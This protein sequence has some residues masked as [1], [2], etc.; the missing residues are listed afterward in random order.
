MGR[1]PEAP[2]NVGTKR[3]MSSPIVANAAFAFGKAPVTCDDP[4]MPSTT[5]CR[6]MDFAKSSST[7]PASP[8]LVEQRFEVWRVAHRGRQLLERPDGG[9]RKDHVEH[10]HARTR[11]KKLIDQLGERIAAPGPGAERF[12]RPFVNVDDANR[13]ACVGRSR[14][15]LLQDVEAQQ[16]QA[17]HEAGV[18]LANGY[19]DRNDAKYDQ[20]V[21]RSDTQPVSA[22]QSSD[23]HALNKTPV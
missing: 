11:G 19:A 4:M 21:D 12:H 13:I 6:A 18:G 22:R 3:R 15:R 7:V 20:P 1:L 17:G 2:A 8:E 23:Q 14:Q 10:H 5:G 9:L 16:A